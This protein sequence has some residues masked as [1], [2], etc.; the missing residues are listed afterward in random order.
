MYSCIFCLPL[1]HRNGVQEAMGAHAVWCSACSVSTTSSSVSSTCSVS[2]G[3]QHLLGES[4]SL[5]DKTS[6]L[7]ESSSLVRG[8]AMGVAGGAS[9]WETAPVAGHVVTGHA[10][11]EPKGAAAAGGST[12]AVVAEGQIVTAQVVQQ[13]PSAGEQAGYGGA[14][15]GGSAYIVSD[16][17]LFSPHDDGYTFQQ[18]RPSIRANKRN[19]CKLCLAFGIAAA[20]GVVVGAVHV[21]GGDGSPEDG[22]APDA[23]PSSSADVTASAPPPPPLPPPLPRCDESAWLS[24]GSVCEDC[25]VVVTSFLSQY[26][27][28]CFNYCG[29]MGFECVGAW[30]AQMDNTCGATTAVPCDVTP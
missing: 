10:A 20:V 19:I 15:F 6:L 28:Q 17:E 23:A 13:R 12:A 25:H 18:Q 3:E 29:A 11:H 27:G 21:L 14:A 8:A 4:S 1:A 5:V 22:I 30:Q 16:N 7:G 9:P 2:I 26:G 24:V